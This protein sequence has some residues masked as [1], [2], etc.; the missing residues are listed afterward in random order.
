MPEPGNPFYLTIAAMLGDDLEESI[1]GKIDAAAASDIYYTRALSYWNL[2][3]YSSAADSFMEAIE[4]YPN[5]QYAG[6]MHWLVANCYEKLKGAGDVNGVDA[7]GIIEWA[8][9][10]LFDKY[11]NCRQVNLAALRLVEINLDKG[12]PATACAYYYWLLDN[13]HEDEG[14]VPEISRLIEGLKECQK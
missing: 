11:P 2:G 6:A 9:Q 10:T 5:H 4:T 13:A 14:R 1:S 12:K 8:Y 3:D 7:D